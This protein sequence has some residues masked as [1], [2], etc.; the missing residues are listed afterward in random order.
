[1]DKIEYHD[2]KMMIVLVTVEHYNA[3]NLLLDNKSL[4]KVSTVSIQTDKRRT[5]LPHKS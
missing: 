2:L 1:M 5:I 3:L 4:D